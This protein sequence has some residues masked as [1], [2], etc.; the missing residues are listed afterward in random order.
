MQKRDYAVELT[1]RDTLRFLGAS[2]ITFAAAAGCDRKPAK[3]PSAAPTRPPM[4]TPS[5]GWDALV[6]GAT[7]EGAFVVATLQS[8]GY[9]KM[10]SDFEQAFPGVKI[11]QTTFESGKEFVTRLFQ[12]RQNGQYL[13]DIALLPSEVVLTGA[14][15]GGALDPLRPLLVHPEV[16]ADTNW[17][18]GFAAGWLDTAQQYSYGITR[19]RSQSLWLNTDQV[20]DGEVQS[21]QDLLDPKW[22]GKILAG[23]PRTKGSAID[24]VTA[25]R[26]TTGDDTLIRRLFKDQE[27]VLKQNAQELTDDTVRGRYPIGLASVTKSFLLDA[28]GQGLARNLKYLPRP[29]FDWIASGANVLHAINGAPHPNAAT[30]FANWVL[31]KDGSTSLANN[32]GE[33]SRRTDVQ[34]V[35]PATL[36]ET[37]LTFVVLDAEAMFDEHARTQEIVKQQLA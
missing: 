12:E 1:R 11:Q 14:R 34:P 16:L 7:T 13:W 37:E 27:V 8:T 31:T 36:P 23:D 19:T 5:G 9:R 21:Y 15:S 4:A 29:E 3:T 35:D 20:Q 30:V 10:L 25:F 28:Q 17:R 2:L 22:K 18:D 6:A 33:N 26:L 32:L 24:M